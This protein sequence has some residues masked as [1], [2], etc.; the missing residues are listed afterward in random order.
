MEKEDF[1]YFVT[2]KCSVYCDVDF[3]LARQLASEVAPFDSR[4]SVLLNNYAD[5]MQ[6]CVDHVSSR[7]EK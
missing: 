3:I 2:V 5:A 7:R 4:L 6:A 1:H